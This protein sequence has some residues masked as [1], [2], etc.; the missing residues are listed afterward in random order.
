MAL[1]LL[2]DVAWVCIVQGLRGK[3]ARAYAAGVEAP[4][5]RSVEMLPPIDSSI[6]T[7]VADLR[8]RPI[9]GTSA[10]GQASRALA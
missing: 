6:S 8:S 10:A 1:K 9:T 7:R 5:E 4:H 2:R 3:V